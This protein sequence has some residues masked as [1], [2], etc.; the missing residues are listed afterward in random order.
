MRAN[1]LVPPLQAVRLH[2]GAGA[3]APQRLSFMTCP[4]AGGK[5]LARQT[6]GVSGA[7]R[8]NPRSRIPK[9]DYYHDSESPGWHI[10]DCPSPLLTFRVDGSGTGTIMSKAYPSHVVNLD[11]CGTKVPPPPSIFRVCLEEY[12]SSGR[13]V[14]Q[15]IDLSAVRL[16]QNTNLLLCDT[17]A[18]GAQLAA[19]ANTSCPGAATFTGVGCARAH[20]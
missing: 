13:S 9:I 1:S 5:P 8:G 16:P 2:T 17:D 12:N 6:W 4:P 20:A 11:N 3:S 14:K 7:F 19:C 15:L 10:W 18:E